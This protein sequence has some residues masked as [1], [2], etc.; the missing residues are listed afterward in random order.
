MDSLK[1]SMQALSDICKKCW[2]YLISL[3]HLLDLQLY[4]DLKF[5]SLWESCGTEI[6]F[7]HQQ[8]LIWFYM[9][10][11]ELPSQLLLPT[12]SHS[13]PLSPLPTTLTHS[14]QPPAALTHSHTFLTKTTTHFS[15]KTTH[16][17]AFFKKSKP[18]PP[19]FRQKRHTP[20]HFFDNHNPLSPIS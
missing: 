14:H 13:H 4:L 3:R 7:S 12:P 16:S 2:L 8:I 15:R 5:K 17:H 10:F 11:T 18:L 1:M 9:G 6:L 20:T 19:I